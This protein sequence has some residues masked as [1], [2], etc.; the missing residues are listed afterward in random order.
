MIR[1][2]FTSSTPREAS[3]APKVE[4]DPMAAMANGLVQRGLGVP[5]VFLLEAM[6]PF[7][8]VTEQTLLVT[9]PLAGLCGQHRLFGQLAHLFGD[10]QRM[11]D[12]ALR[13]EQLM[14]EPQAAKTISTEAGNE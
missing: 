14:E 4:S 3:M 10:R 11:E 12:L 8:L 2:L 1:S 5:A 6:K 13:V 7:S 9:T